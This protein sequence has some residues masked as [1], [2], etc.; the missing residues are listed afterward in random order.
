MKYLNLFTII[1]LTF[2]VSLL[3]FLSSQTLSRKDKKAIKRQRDNVGKI[4]NL[5]SIGDIGE[6]E[7]LATLVKKTQQGGNDEDNGAA[8]MDFD[9]DFSDEKLL[10]NISLQRTLNTLAQKSKK[11]SKSVDFSDDVLFEN[12]P[13]ANK[14]RSKEVAEEEPEDDMDFEEPSSSRKRRPMPEEAD[15]NDLLQAFTKKKHEYLAKKQSHYTVEPKYGSAQSDT[16]GED[17]KRAATYEM[18]ANKGLTPHRNKI[19]RNARVKKRVKYEK[20][21]SN[22]KGQQRTLRVGEAAAYGGEATGIKA[23]LSRSRKF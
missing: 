4:Q 2:Y 20:A 21:L 18:I 17:E 10:S 1:Q 9:N 16:I 15:E 5:E 12:K 8:D 22:L 13:K 7:E 14:K 6:F 11:S 19:N 3:I 23:N